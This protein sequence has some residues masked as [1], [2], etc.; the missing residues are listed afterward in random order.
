MK[1]DQITESDPK[2]QVVTLTKW[3]RIKGAHWIS[4]VGD[5]GNPC[6]KVHGHDWRVGVKVGGRL[7]CPPFTIADTEAINAAFWSVVGGDHVN[8][9][10]LLATEYASTEAIGLYIYGQLATGSIGGS[11]LGVQVYES[12]TLCV[13]VSR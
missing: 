3:Y 1:L 5:D 4:G 11:L 13:E 8:W 6:R 9:N 7:K 10:E 12:D 2:R